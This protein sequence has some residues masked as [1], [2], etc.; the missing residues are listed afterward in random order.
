MNLFVAPVGYCVSTVFE[1]LGHVLGVFFWDLD[2]VLWVLVD[3]PKSEYKR[4]DW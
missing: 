4:V 3:E 1:L 2:V